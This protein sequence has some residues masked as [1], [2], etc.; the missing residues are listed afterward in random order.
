MA[1]TNV[2]CQVKV[3]GK[4]SGSFATTKGLRRGVGLVCLLFNLEPGAV[5]E[6]PEEGQE[7]KAV[8][9]PDK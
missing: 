9:A 2:T 4:H 1:M 7:R 8:V 5:S 3:D 6:T